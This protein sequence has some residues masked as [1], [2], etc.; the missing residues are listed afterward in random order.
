MSPSVSLGYR[1]ILYYYYMIIGVPNPAL[2]AVLE[3]AKPVTTES[4]APFAPFHRS[5]GRSTKSDDKRRR[6]RRPRRRL[7]GCADRTRL[8]A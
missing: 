6:G 2:N 3:H 8:W 5:I 7:G 1:S 4:K